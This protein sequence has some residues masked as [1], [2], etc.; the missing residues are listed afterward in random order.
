MSYNVCLSITDYINGC[1]DTY[2]HSVNLPYLF[3]SSYVYSLSGF[4]FSFTDTSS[5]NYDEWLW[6]FGDGTTD[7]IANPTHIFPAIGNYWVCL[8]ISDSAGTCY[9]AS[10]QDIYAPIDSNQQCSA[11]FTNM[12]TDSI[13]NNN[14]SIE[15][16]N[17]SVSAN[18]ITSWN[19][20][21][22]DGNTSALQNPVHGYSA[23]GTYDVCLTITDNS[24]C[25]NT[26]CDTVNLSTSNCIAAFTDSSS[27]TGVQF[28]D[29]SMAGVHTNFWTFGDGATS[30]QTNPSHSYALPA[31]NSTCNINSK[32]YFLNSFIITAK[33]I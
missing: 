31:N 23:M 25:S 21:F 4:T 14:D 27:G 3:Y 28:T 15:F 10:C 12:Y 13:I 6:N 29:Q 1:S 22:G 20:D 16:L 8:T 32:L 30:N 7:T 18:Q 17:C 19:W 11:C 26:Y 24:G 2:F 9:S 33:K 5:G